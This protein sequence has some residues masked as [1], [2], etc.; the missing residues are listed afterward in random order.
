M[1]VGAP[2]APLI[3]C[4]AHVWGPDMPY[5]ANAWKRLDYVYPVERYIA[6][7]D[8]HGVQYGVIA[9]AS[10]FGTYNDYSLEALRA[11]KRL[12]A[13]ANV[14][15]DVDLETL[16][17]L[18]AAGMVGI[19]LQW[20]FLDPLPDMGA[21]FQLLCRRLCDLDM[22]IHLN[23]NGARLVDVAS[24]IMDTGVRLV[25]DHFG[26]HD[27][28]PRLNAP[29]YQGMLKLLDR[30]NAWVKITSGYRH[31]DEH[32]PDWSLPADYA[33]D[34]LQRFG[35]GKLLWGSDAPFIGHEHVASYAL[36]VERFR[37]CVPDAAQRRAI[38]ENGYCFYFGE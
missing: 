37:L 32:F 34:L 35:S 14:D 10:L 11:H 23:I 38:G 21:A 6:D 4:H 26:W 8:A 5:A 20:F 29:S 12:R 28:A 16:R 2:Q 3:D 30:G 17:S 19:R 22:H 33:Q 27:P 18:R 1:N 7:L 25:V 15:M 13:T 36:A 31:P 24:R 9:A